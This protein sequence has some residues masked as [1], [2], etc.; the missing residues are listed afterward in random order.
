[1]NRKVTVI[2][3]REQLEQNHKLDVRVVPLKVSQSVV[4]LVFLVFLFSVS[5]FMVA[6][7]PPLVSDA[8]SVSIFL[9]VFLLTPRV[10]D[11]SASAQP[12]ANVCLISFDFPDLHVNSDVVMRCPRVVQSPES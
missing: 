6:S 2:V 9:L 3:E 10:L 8:A 5:C 7:I 11:G 4:F 1:M 12:L